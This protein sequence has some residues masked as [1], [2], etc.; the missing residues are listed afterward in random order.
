MEMS[1]GPKGVTSVYPME[2]RPRGRATGE[3]E[4]S[5]PATKDEGPDAVVSISTR[6][7]SLSQWLAVQKI[8]EAQLDEEMK[9]VDSRKTAEAIMK[10]LV[11][12]LY[13]ALVDA[14]EVEE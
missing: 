9:S 1:T 8:D 14:G 10:R 12:D 7:S 3:T 2:L 13:Q 4:R 5:A 6:A 11:P